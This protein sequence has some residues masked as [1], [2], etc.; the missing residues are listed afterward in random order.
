MTAFVD[1]S[2]RFANGTLATKQLGDYRAVVEQDMAVRYRIAFPPSPTPRPGEAKLPEN[3]LRGL[4]HELVQHLRDLG[5]LPH[6]DF[7]H[8]H[9][10]KNAILH[11]AEYLLPILAAVKLYLDDDAE[12]ASARLPTH[13]TPNLAWLGRHLPTLTERLGDFTSWDGRLAPPAMASYKATEVYGRSLAYRLRTLSSEQF[14]FLS[15]EHLDPR[16]LPALNDLFVAGLKVRGAATRRS[17]PIGFWRHLADIDLLL[18]R[19]IRNTTHRSDSALLYQLT[20]GPES[21]IPLEQL[22][23]A[24][25]TAPKLDAATYSVARAKRII[26]KARRRGDRTDG[27]LDV[28][29]LQV[30][31]W[32]TGFYIGAIDGEWGPLSHLALKTFVGDEA[33][34]ALRGRP[35][36]EAKPKH[37]RA[38]AKIRSLL[39]PANREH[40]V[41]V[42]DLKG[43]I[44]LFTDRNTRL[45]PQDDS[46]T[47]LA[48]LCDRAGIDQ[49]RLDR[50]VLAESGT[51]KL[52]PDNVAAPE[53]RVSYPKQNWFHGLWGGLRRVVQ[54]LQTG[55]KA[56]A[57]VVIGPVFNFVKQLL[58][59][60]RLAVTQ[61]FTGFRYL[62]NFIL[63]RPIVTEVGR[64][65]DER[66]TV[67]A[68]KF[69]VDFDAVT[70]APLTFERADSSRHA[71]HL[72]SFRAD[73]FYFIDV[74]ILL[75]SS[76]GKLSNPGGW[77]GLGLE[78]FRLSRLN[79]PTEKGLSP[80][81][82]APL[83]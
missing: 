46:A 80:D 54:W 15:S 8:Y 61:F 51:A 11:R 2:R 70:V 64:S 78:I 81:Y 57:A 31:L 75:I 7:V 49:E 4:W 6:A 40:R 50:L 1:L 65:L 34:E 27:G 52:Y 39:L 48:A 73:M 41:Y 55:V 47:T 58:R 76:I 62:A 53:R 37:R 21:V 20:D 16:D 72:D 66:A 42:A 5:Y 67:F 26:K 33:N 69:S 3:H 79:R 32:Q 77:V 63:G 28:R 68:T 25:F 17:I 74:T 36:G 44:K 60:I 18:T 23:D 22:G 82:R 35:I 83:A 30:K 45:G 24:A 38:A 10:H 19:Y 13:G 71:D 29:L 59:P 56:A 14:T 9:Q 12:W 43:L